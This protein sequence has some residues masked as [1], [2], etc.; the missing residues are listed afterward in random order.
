MKKVVSAGCNPGLANKGTCTKIRETVM[1]KIDD[2]VDEF[3][4]QLG[5]S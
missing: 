1:Q 5:I 2:V 3:G 4:R